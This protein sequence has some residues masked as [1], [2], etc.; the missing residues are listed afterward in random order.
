MVPSFSRKLPYAV[1]VF[2]LV[3]AAWMVTATATDLGAPL[4]VS[5]D[6]KGVA[7][8]GFSIQANFSPDGTHLLFWSSSTNLVTGNRGFPQL[9]IKDLTTGAVAFV[10]ADARGNA[11]N[12]A[13][14]NPNNSCQVRMFSPDGTKV[15]FESE[16]T[17]LLE[18]NLVPLVTNG[19]AH[20]FVKDLTTGA[21][22][23]VSADATGDA[24]GVHQGNGSSMDFAFSPD[25]TKV[26]FDSA[27]TNLV[28]GGS[29][30]EQVFIKDLTTGAVTLASTDANGVEGNG[31]S[32]LPVFS[33]DGTEV[34]FVSLSSNLP[35]ATDFTAQ[36]YV[37]NIV[38]GAITLASTDANSNEFSGQNQLP[39]FSPDGSKVAFN[40]LLPTGNRE[41][42]IK[43]L[44]T[45]ALTLVS[46]DAIGVQAE[47]NTSKLAV[48][49]PDGMEI[50]FES[51]ATNLVPGGSSGEQ[52]FIKNLT[53]GAVTLASTDA[54][55]VPGNSSSSD[56]NFSP[57]RTALAFQSTA[58]NLGVTNGTF[59]IFVRQI[60]VAP[61]VTTSPSS[62]TI[63]AGQTA[64]FTAAATGTP[65]PTVQ[66]QVSTD[67][68][69]SFS[70][71]AGATS[72]TLTF[73]ASLSQNGNLYQAVF[74]N[75]AGSATSSAAK[76]TVINPAT[77]T[78]LVSSANPSTFGQPVTFT[79]TV[80]SPAGIPTG[81][82]TFLDGASSLGT[83]TLDSSGM[84]TLTTASLAVGGHSITASYGGDTNFNP[85][86]SSALSQTVN[87]SA[88]M[89][90]A[91]S[92]ANPSVFG[93]AVTFTATV[94]SPAGI[95]TGT[96]TFLDGATS[97]GTGTLDSSGMATL[98]TASLAVG[99]HSIT[100]SYGGDTNFNPSNSSPLAQTVNKG[101]T[102]VTAISS[103]N[104]SVFGQPVTFTATV[105][106]AA[107]I[108]TGTVTFLDGATSLGTGAL[109]SS[110]IAT[111]TTAS[112][113]VGAHSIT[114]SYG[115]D[116]NFNPSSSSALSQTVNKGP[117]TVASISSANPSV[118]GQGVIFS[119]AVA[120]AAPGA[121]SPTG[122][123]TFQ[124]GATSL[125]TSGII[126]GQALFTTSS[127]AVG[128]HSVTA[129]YNGDGNFNGAS[130]APVA[131]AVNKAASSTSVASSAN[132]AAFAQP[133]TFT[134][135]V[136]AVAPGAGTP[137][138]AVDFLDG[139]T[140]LGT[141]SLTGGQA[142]FTSSSLSI[143]SHSI[144]VV[145]VGDGNF[146]GSTSAPLTETVTKTAAL[147]TLSSSPNPSLLNQ[148]V[149]LTA[150]VAAVPPAVGTPTGTVAFQDGA[151]AL[152]T[153]TLSSSGVATLTLSTLAVGSHSLTAVYSGD[154]GFSGATS[155]AL[156]Q[157]VQ[158]APAG[159][160][161][162]GEAGHQILPPIDPAGSSVWKQ[163]R[164]VPAKFRVC[165]ANGI[166]IGTPGVVSSFFLIEILKGTA[167]SSVQDVVETD[168]PDTAFRWDP[169]SQQWIFNITTA[170]LA[171][172]NTYVY[173]I[174][175]NDGSV[176]YFQYGLK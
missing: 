90:T 66:W 111:L 55:G 28:P 144:T 49:S 21:V 170:D 162:D 156:T 131:Q 78:V 139:G 13:S 146:N 87:K 93:Q 47:G 119:A 109:D 169:T 33:P 11:G 135:T 176:I 26:A 120:P 68:G 61:A 60:L 86:S 159:T 100:T 63:T 67:G 20:I 152:G 52:V 130:S 91:I 72:T 22:T 79:A 123:V 98:T 53:T 17:N 116:A 165:D 36:I 155:A 4:L 153:A 15:V 73:T 31:S 94:S 82:V 71:I 89:V 114:A 125:G 145:Y 149:V 46:S 103:A 76:L 43:D 59:Q 37:K 65:P 1:G 35:G 64:S 106:S 138:G 140:A 92:S 126:N 57:D 168:I 121:G 95:P 88:T 39:M 25:G 7:G 148:P 110:G 6:S 147:V 14:T 27:A 23:L 107:G 154:A 141:A 8:N 151:T 96:V 172:G 166:S 161:C 157:T 58:S 150:K 5:T 62:L 101:A 167:T 115:G 137:T 164:T 97:L 142:T 3:L 113:A 42:F 75:S 30:G 129:V 44:V 104:P 29:S 18:N 143:A 175:L 81:T 69:V 122:T 128:S 108:P 99:A 12:N 24:S 45:R 173:A 2:A 9:Y 112:L 118:F 127:L 16:A 102:T 70:D 54:N 136:A 158:Y 117:T 85:S 10:S 84:A 105:S 19:N 124:D 80:S 38:T 50:A 160:S 163:H 174:T 74:S 32:S 41:I 132:P 40:S 56:P 77:T 34:A 83:G 48:F 133:V 51:A 171:A 134:A